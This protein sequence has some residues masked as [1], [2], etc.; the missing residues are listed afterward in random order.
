MRKRSRS[1]WESSLL[2]RA[3]P[4]SAQSRRNHGWTLLNADTDQSTC[5]QVISKD[6]NAFTQLTTLW[7]YSVLEARNRNA[8]SCWLA[9]LADVLAA[10]TGR[11]VSLCSPGQ[12]EL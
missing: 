12:I 7:F 11:G 2:R 3:T 1:V 9:K 10:T 5:S 8:S 6:T 4:N